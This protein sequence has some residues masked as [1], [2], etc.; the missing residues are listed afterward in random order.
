MHAPIVDCLAYPETQLLKPH[1][2]HISHPSVIIS[3]ARQDG[4][5]SFSVNPYCELEGCVCIG[6]LAVSIFERCWR[7]TL[8]TPFSKS[9]SESGPCM[10][11]KI[12]SNA[13]RT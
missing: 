12:F 2:M 7:S 6:A 9:S 10:S 11:L 3:F 5:N 8:S 13:P 4:Q 1:S